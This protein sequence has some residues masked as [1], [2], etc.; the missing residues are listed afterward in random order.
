VH[1]PGLAVRHHAYAKRDL[2]REAVPSPGPKGVKSLEATR[3]DRR[4]T[5]R[6]HADDGGEHDIAGRRDAGEDRGDS[7]ERRSKAAEDQGFDAGLVA[8]DGHPDPVRTVTSGNGSFDREYR[9]P[10]KP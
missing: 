2:A 10:T 9:Y 6:R 1:Q 4:E 7:R 5:D 3:R 8:V